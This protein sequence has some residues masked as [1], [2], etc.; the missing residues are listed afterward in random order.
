M[1]AIKVRWFVPLLVLSFAVAALLAPGSGPRSVAA[2]HD[3]VHGKHICIDPGHGGDQPGAVNAAFGLLERRSDVTNFGPANA[4]RVE[5]IGI[6]LLFEDGSRSYAVI[7]WHD[8]HL[9]IAEAIAP[10]GMPPPLLFSTSLGFLDEE[11]RRITYGGRY[12][13]LDPVPPRTR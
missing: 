13:P 10:R 9:F 4:E 6:Q 12:A 8:Y 11:G 1:S 7:F 3:L 2:D 5:G